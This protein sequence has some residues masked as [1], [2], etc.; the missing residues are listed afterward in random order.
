MQAQFFFYLLRQVAALVII[1]F[2]RQLYAFCRQA[3]AVRE[4][5]G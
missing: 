2:L 4:E 5:I 3:I 1:K